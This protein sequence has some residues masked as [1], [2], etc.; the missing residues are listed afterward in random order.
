MLWCG[1]T[2]HSEKKPFWTSGSCFGS[3][4]KLLWNCTQSGIYAEVSKMFGF[5]T[6]AENRQT[7][8]FSIL[9]YQNSFCSTFYSKRLFF[10][11]R[12]RFRG[13]HFH[14]PARGKGMF[15]HIDSKPEMTLTP[16]RFLYLC[17]FSI[18]LKISYNAPVSL[19]SDLFENFNKLVQIL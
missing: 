15:F 4:S 16:A 3:V 19:T 2:N 11:F 12:T 14:S 1:K 10:C 18:F 9:L 17:H 8:H 6:P 13:F 7:L 5:V